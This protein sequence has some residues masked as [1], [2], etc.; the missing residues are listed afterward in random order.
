M[1][2]YDDTAKAEMAEQLSEVLRQMNTIDPPTYDGLAA[3]LS[4]FVD[5]PEDAGYDI[6]RALD[7]AGLAIVPKEPTEEMRAPFKNI[8]EQHWR[9]YK[10]PGVYATML[11][12]SPFILRE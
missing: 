12:A 11:S 10:A 8:L 6:L 3:W 5:Y 1:T 2:Q 7:S 4:E 9:D